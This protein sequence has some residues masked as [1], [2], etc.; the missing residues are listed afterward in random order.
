MKMECGLNMLRNSKN[1][2][3]HHF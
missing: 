1:S 2:K 3:P